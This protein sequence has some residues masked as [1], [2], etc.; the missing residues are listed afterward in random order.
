VGSG[1]I[2]GIGP[3]GV[4]IEIECK[5]GKG[6]LLS[7]AQQRRRD[8]VMSHGGKY[9]VVHS[10]NELEQWYGDVFG[11]SAERGSDEDAAEEDP[12]GFDS[13]Q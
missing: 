12:E 6:G 2:I 7:V 10:V 3:G 11:S 4:H 13:A 8:R 5:A 9:T 1:D